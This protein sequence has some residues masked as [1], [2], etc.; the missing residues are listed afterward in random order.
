MTSKHR[1]GNVSVVGRPRLRD[2][3]APSL[4]K[5]FAQRICQFQY[6]RLGFGSDVVRLAALAFEKHSKI[7]NGRIRQ[8]TKRAAGAAVTFENNVAMTHDVR[9]EISEDAAIVERHSGSIGVRYP[10]DS[11]GN[12]KLRMPA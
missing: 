4:W 11:D 3:F 1:T 9:H 10:C 12:S 7:S 2:Y 6:G 8:V 5:E